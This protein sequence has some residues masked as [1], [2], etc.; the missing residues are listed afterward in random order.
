MK[1]GVGCPKDENEGSVEFKVECNLRTHAFYCAADGTIVQCSR[2]QQDEVE[3]EEVEYDQDG[4]DDNVA[5][6]TIL[7][8]NHSQKKLVS[9]EAKKNVQKI[10]SGQSSLKTLE[11][12]AQLRIVL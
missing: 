7:K 12:L 11:L 9:L 6:V 4:N 1:L 10:M 8:A 3:G 2:V 5:L